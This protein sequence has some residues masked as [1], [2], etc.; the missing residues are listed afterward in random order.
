MKKSNSCS[1]SPVS[2]RRFV[3][4]SCSG[5]LVRIFHDLAL[6]VVLVGQ[7]VALPLRNLLL[8]ANPD[9]FGNLKAEKRVRFGM[10]MLLDVKR[11][12]LTFLTWLTPL[13]YKIVLT[14]PK[15]SS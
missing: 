9:L 14:T 2:S 13:N 7:D 5:V 10:I 4:S 12:I 1:S 15:Q 3:Q 8:L 11:F 6:Q